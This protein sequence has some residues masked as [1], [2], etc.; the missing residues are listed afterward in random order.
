MKL[1]QGESD[2]NSEE[3]GAVNF[4]ALIS[5]PTTGMKT[6]KSI[7]GPKPWGKEWVFSGVK[8]DNPDFKPLFQTYGLTPIKKQLCRK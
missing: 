7:A 1:T 3:S 4:S 8:T 2:E 6:A 5:D